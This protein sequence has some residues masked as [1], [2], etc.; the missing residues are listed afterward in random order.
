MDMLIEKPSKIVET[1]A[2]K[3]QSVSSFFYIGPA[4]VY[5]YRPRACTAT[6]Q[7]DGQEVWRSNQ[8]AGTQFSDPRGQGILTHQL[9]YILSLQA[10]FQ[11]Q[12]C[13]KVRCTVSGFASP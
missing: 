1:I 12:F 13:L 4:I 3:C 11:R 2:D 8:C 7:L 10:L 6:F 9:V 5:M